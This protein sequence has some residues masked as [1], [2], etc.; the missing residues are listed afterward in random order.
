[1]ALICLCAFWG[2]APAEGHL[3]VVT[4][5]LL[6][7][8]KG[9][10]SPATQFFLIPF[11]FIEPQPRPWGPP[12]LGR[13]RGLC[14]I[15]FSPST[16]L[17]SLGSWVSRLWTASA[18]LKFTYP[19]GKTLTALMA[20]QNSGAYVIS[21]WLPEDAHANSI[22]LPRGHPPSPQCISQHV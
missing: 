21:E 13:A 16:E 17:V 14:L 1:M 19:A 11:S 9:P 20:Q 10:L 2:A 3:P 5:F 8:C 18:S 4:P 7:L 6:I 22:S 15:L 12:C